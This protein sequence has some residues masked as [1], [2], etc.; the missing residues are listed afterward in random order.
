MWGPTATIDTVSPARPQSIVLAVGDEL[1]G[2]FVADSNSPWLARRLWQAGFPA[3]RLEVVGDDPEAI[4]AAVRRAVAEPAARILVSGGL[5]P[6]A[7]DRTLEAV[8]HALDLP[9]EEHPAALAHVQGVVER[10]W[11][12]G[13]RASPELGAANRKMT[14]APR[15]AEVVVNRRGMAPGLAIALAGGDHLGR[16]LFV[17]PGVPRELQTMVEEELL[18]R[19]FTGSVADAVEEVRFCATAEADLVGTIAA[20]EREFPDVRIGSY[21]QTESRELLIRFSGPDPATVAA[22]VARL[23]ALRPRL[24]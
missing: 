7:D 2:G 17:L 23:R 24:E 14:L 1:L 16:W 4:V 20:V 8:A 22:A 15:G 5:G 13:W 18:P 21:P 11:Q 12:A 19:Y 3:R 6:T 10:M 9:L